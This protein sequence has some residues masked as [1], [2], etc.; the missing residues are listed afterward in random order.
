MFDSIAHKCKGGLRVLKKRVQTQNALKI[1][2]SCDLNLEMEIDK[3]YKNSMKYGVGG[4]SLNSQS[5]LL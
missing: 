2:C 4:T 3:N 1:E 5:N